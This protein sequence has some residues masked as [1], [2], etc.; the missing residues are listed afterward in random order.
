MCYW[1]S[2]RSRRGILEGVIDD[3]GYF[4]SREE[5]LEVLSYSAMFFLLFSLSLSLSL[6]LFSRPF[7]CT[8][9]KR[10]R[11]VMHIIDCI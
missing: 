4:F 6:S 7:S 3:G 9:G 2:R 5:T 1:G 10:G 11:L 8:P